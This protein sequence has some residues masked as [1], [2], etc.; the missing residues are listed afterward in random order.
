MHEYVLYSQIPDERIDTAVQVL[1]GYTRSQP[2][3]LGEQTIIYAQVKLPE[4]VVSRKH[5]QPKQLHLNNPRPIYEKL[6]RSL[7]TAQQDGGPPEPLNDDWIFRVE[8]TPDPAV[9]ATKP[10][11]GKTMHIS[12]DVLERPATDKDMDR[13]Q[14]PE[15]YKYRH[16]YTLSGHQFVAGN[17]VIRVYRFHEEEYAGNPINRDLFVP[18][19][20]NLIDQSGAW[21]VEAVVRVEDPSIT[22]IM[23]AAKRELAHFRVAMEGALDL[24]APD[25]LT[26][27]TRVRDI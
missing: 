17:I 23:D 8:Q 3:Y 24:Y 15:W 14:E 26:L 22:K 7:T 20:S 21:V 16:Q 13:F 27:D 19:E 6:K 9:E 18:T 12:R 1:A 11:S 4:A 10:G 25:R 5:G 2:V